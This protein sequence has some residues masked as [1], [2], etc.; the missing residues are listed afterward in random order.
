MAAEPM[1]PCRVDELQIE[2]QVRPL[3]HA[4]VSVRASVLATALRARVLHCVLHCVE[5][6]GVR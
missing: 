2:L 3:G 4:R 6:L 5:C 1:M